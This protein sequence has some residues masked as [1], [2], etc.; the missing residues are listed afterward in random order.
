MSPFT[1][2]DS[3]F[4]NFFMVYAI[5]ILVPYWIVVKALQHRGASKPRVNE[6]TAMPYHI[7]YLRDGFRD[8][9]RVAVVN[10]VDRGLLVRV[11]SQ[12]RRARADSLEFARHPIEK[13]LLESCTALREADE[14]HRLP[15][16]QA[17]QPDYEAR[18]G[19]KGLLL[20]RD[21]RRT[22]LMGFL[23]VALLIAGV[24]IGRALHA[25]R[26]GDADVLGLLIVTFI[27]LSYAWAIARH[28]IS[29]AGRHALESLQGLLERTA[30]RLE[31]GGATNAA[32]L[33][34]SAFGVWALPPDEFPFVEVLFPKP[35]SRPG[36]GDEGEGGIELGACGGCGGGGGCGG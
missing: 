35:K 8:T 20:S 7:A 32:L 18:L 3:G 25:L 14:L 17:A 31:A 28:R 1:L 2:D 10:L 15:R 5:A 11:G 13:A 36:R 21:A 12:V 16:V 29:A 4:M 23:L 33:Y 26:H 22:V 27:A 9:V 24:A 6:L 19:A 34:A 30:R